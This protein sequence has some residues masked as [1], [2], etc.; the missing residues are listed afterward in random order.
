MGSIADWFRRTT[1]KPA[2]VV[3]GMISGT[4]AD[5]IDAAVCR[6]SGSGVPTADRE[7]ARVELLHYG[8]TPYEP[9]LKTRV[10]NLAQW[11]V[12]AVAEL[13]VE[14]GEAF[15]RACL[16]TVA[17]AGLK[18]SDVDLI[19]S[20]GQTV[21][22]HSS[23]PGAI[24]AT[25][26]VGDGDVIAERT[27]AMVVCDFRARDIAG[28]GEGAPIS[29]YADMILYAPRDRK[30]ASDRRAVLN[31]GGIANV[32]V[33]DPDSSRVFGFDTGPANTLLDRLARRLSDG[34]LS[35]DRDGAMARAGRVDEGLVERLLAEDPF[36]ARRPPKSTGFE[37]YGDAFVER[38][39]G[40]L[41]RFDAD[42]MATLTE[43]TARTVADAFARF[44]PPVVEVI[45]A[46]GGVK[47]PVLIGRIAELLAPARFVLGDDR[48]VPGDA[49][50]AMAF[51]ILANDA[52]HGLPTSLPAVTGARRPATLGKFCL[53]NDWRG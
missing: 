10:Q 33:L 46:G 19:G 45:G 35:C 4:S 20:H 22:H 21:Y 3:V 27:G 34:S 11:D 23:V 28:G 30:S 42:L 9:E 51:A 14:V 17:E 15:A 40:L 48:G 5:S 38:A 52:L 25:L 29:P 18:P 44:V 6:I 50:E 31:L 37:M 13:N 24:G 16:K 53:P 39:G 8:E 32:T 2:R 49:R 41:G 26:Q 36:L 12:R 43:F 7:G 47:N 1:E